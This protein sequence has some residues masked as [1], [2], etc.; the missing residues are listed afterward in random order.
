MTKDPGECQCKDNICF[1]GTVTFDLSK[2]PWQKV[3]RFKLN[4]SSCSYRIFGN[5]MNNYIDPGPC[6]AL[7][8][9][10]LIGGNGSD[11]YVFGHEYGEFNVMNNFGEDKAQDTL[12]MGLIFEDIQILFDNNSNVFLAS[13]TKPVSLTVKLESYFVGEDFQHI[14][15]RTTEVVK[16]SI[17]ERFP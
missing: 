3:V 11:T 15:V 10:Y 6:N 2:N 12:E 5:G 13:K 9:Q 8:E 14:V 7:S 4:S 16:F 1:E 17:V